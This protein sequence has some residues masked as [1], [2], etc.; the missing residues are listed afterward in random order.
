MT[1]EEF[2]QAFVKYQ[3]YY[4]EPVMSK[5]MKSIY[6]LGLKDLTVEQLNSAY[7][8]IIRTRNFQKMPKIAEIRENA[9]GETKELM[10]LRMQMAREKILFAI[11]KY[12]IYQSV[13]FDDKGIHALID[14]AGGWQK[15]CAMEQNEFED[16]FKYNNFEKIYGAYWKLPRN[17]SQNYL[18]LHDNEN[19]TMKIKYITNSD[20]G[21]NNQQNN[22]IGNTHK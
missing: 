3:E 1:L 6:F 13:E 4:P 9:L 16:L 22:L 19:G 2:T 14:S 21:V 17:V 5:E 15:I 8:E 20:I 12:G 11:R 7:V 18:G 10:N